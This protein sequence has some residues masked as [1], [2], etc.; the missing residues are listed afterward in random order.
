MCDGLGAISVRT[1]PGG[2]VSQ[3]DWAMRATLVCGR[4][5]QDAYFVGDG[6]TLAH[7]PVPDSHASADPD[8]TRPANQLCTAQGDWVGLHPVIDDR[9]NS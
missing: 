8:G 3:F 2:V 9:D 4:V 5:R 1:G 7:I 6:A